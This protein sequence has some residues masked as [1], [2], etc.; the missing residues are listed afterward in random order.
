[1]GLTGYYCRFVKNYGLIARPLTD[2]TKKDAFHWS[3]K[4][5]EAFENLKHALTTTLVLQLS[6]FKLPFTME[7]DASS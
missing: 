3:E 5:Q 6:N 2:L 1:M 4:A 7:C